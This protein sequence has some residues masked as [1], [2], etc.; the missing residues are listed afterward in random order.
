MGGGPGHMLGP[1]SG[2]SP[3]LHASQAA[4]ILPGLA[5]GL[6]RRLRQLW[7][8]L[9]PAT[10]SNPA[11]LPCAQAA[12]S[13]LCR[14]ACRQLA[15]AA[16]ER[17]RSSWASTTCERSP[18]CQTLA[19]LLLGR[20]SGRASNQARP[21]SLCHCAP[22][23]RPD[24]TIDTPPGS[25][26]SAQLR[27]C[28]NDAKCMEYLLKTKVRRGWVGPGCKERSRFGASPLAAQHVRHARWALL[29][30]GCWQPAP[31]AC[32]APPGPCCTAVWV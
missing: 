6:G 16:G 18:G 13:T 20:H 9:Q 3:V 2:A 26:T 29:A 17:R 24:F 4:S 12:G 11:C 21:L 15:P 28:I 30:G 25:G 32:H 23:A 10:T 22:L 5:P 27:G 1:T 19:E 7:R 14:Q 31:P 8:E